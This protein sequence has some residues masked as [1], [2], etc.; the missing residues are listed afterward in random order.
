V[1]Q[2]ER[3]HDREG[4]CRRENYRVA[5]NRESRRRERER[6]RQGVTLWA[7][8]GNGGSIDDYAVDGTEDQ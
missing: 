6:E 5:G 3:Q 4:W 1:C 8:N 7:E 2:D